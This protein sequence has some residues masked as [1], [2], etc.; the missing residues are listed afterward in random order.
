MK[1]PKSYPIPFFYAA[2]IACFFIDLCFF[3]CYEKPLIHSSLCLFIV[4]LIRH[5]NALQ[6]ASALL[7]LSLLSFI[8]YGHFG[9]ILLALIPLTFIGLWIRKELYPSWWYPYL[10]LVLTLLIQHLILERVIL[11]LTISLFYTILTIFANMI[12]MFIVSLK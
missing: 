8:Y 12:V 9:L 2:A 4:A 6:I 10:L 5:S 7:T 11:S 3:S 1:H